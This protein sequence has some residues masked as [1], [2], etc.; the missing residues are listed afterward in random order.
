M[1]RNH[2]GAAQQ[3]GHLL[4]VVPA[5]LGNGSLVVPRWK[6]LGR[7]VEIEGE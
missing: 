5:V 6:E 4:N 7:S 1:N 3:P 2:L